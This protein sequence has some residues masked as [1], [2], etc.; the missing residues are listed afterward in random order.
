MS[1]VT[2]IIAGIIALGAVVASFISRPWAPAAAFIALAIAGSSDGADISGAT[3]IFWMAAAVIVTIIV[4]TLPRTVARSTTGVAY[5]AGA[6]LAGLF[7]GICI[8][9]AAI[10]IGTVTGAILG[11]IA[12]CRTPSGRALGF[13]GKKAVNY[14]CAK[15]FPIV[16]TFCI[17]G[18]LIAAVTMSI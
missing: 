15:A 5:I 1:T 9:H 12:Y 6:A 4:M 8:S 2:I 17:A 3:L 14:L 13:P 10:I 7:I 11:A 18:E 16:I